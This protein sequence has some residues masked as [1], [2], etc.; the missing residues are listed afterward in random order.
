VSC[1]IARAA[2]AA[3]GTALRAVHPPKNPLTGPELIAA[4]VLCAHLQAPVRSRPCSSKYRYGVET[5]RSHRIICARPCSPSRPAS[6]FAH[7]NE[8]FLNKTQE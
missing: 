2:E 5:E 6:R 7:T 3:G 1:A 4:T 8:L